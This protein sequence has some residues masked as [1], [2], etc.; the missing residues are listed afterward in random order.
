MEVINRVC[1]IMGMITDANGI[2]HGCSHGHIDGV[3]NGL[4]LRAQC[5][6]FIS[7]VDPAVLSSWSTISICSESWVA[8]K[9]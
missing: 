7:A 5:P 6:G 2:N 8:L 3:T 1:A 4:H 9:W